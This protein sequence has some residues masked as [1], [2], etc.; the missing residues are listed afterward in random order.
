MTEDFD[1][2]GIER[3]QPTALSAVQEVFENLPA[4]AAIG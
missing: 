3:A 2:F 1:F 4:L